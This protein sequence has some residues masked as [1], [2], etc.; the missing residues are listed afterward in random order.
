MLC[1][2]ASSVDLP[3]GKWSTYRRTPLSTAWQTPQ[4]VRLHGSPPA[5]WP[6]AWHSELP[7]RQCQQHAARS[8]GPSGVCR[9]RLRWKSVLHCCAGGSHFPWWAGLILGLGLALIILAVLGTLAVRYVLRLRH[10]NSELASS[11]RDIESKVSSSAASIF[12]S[13]ADTHAFWH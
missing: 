5:S 10:Q 13:V 12:F 11:Q 6:A 3:A 2:Q 1:P 8:V 4:E 9:Q 7:P